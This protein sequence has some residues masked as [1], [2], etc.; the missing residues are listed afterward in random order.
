MSLKLHHQPPEHHQPFHTTIFDLRFCVL[1]WG[2]RS[3]WQHLEETFCKC[4][5]CTLGSSVVMFILGMW[6]KHSKWLLENLVTKE[7]YS[8]LWDPRPAK[9]PIFVVLPFFPTSP[10][11]S[12][13]NGRFQCTVIS[14]LHSIRKCQIQHVVTFPDSPLCLQGH[15]WL[16]FPRHSQ[17]Q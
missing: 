11:P 15:A 10:P 14:N 4:E 1:R 7:H 13:H 8:L 17:A 16:P 6:S 2:S 9:F 12:S 5:T 3:G